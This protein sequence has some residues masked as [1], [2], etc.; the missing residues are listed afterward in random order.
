M[1]LC[2]NSVVCLLKPGNFIA[3]AILLNFLSNIKPHFKA[4]SQKLP[5]LQCL[6]S[7]VFVSDLCLLVLTVSGIRLVI[8]RSAKFVLGALTSSLFSL[9]SRP[10]L[11]FLLCPPYPLLFLHTTIL[12][13]IPT[14]SSK[15]CFLSLGEFII[16]RTSLKFPSPR[17]PPFI[18]MFSQTYVV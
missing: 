18:P 17:V 16:E 8:L 7:M 3:D 13:P 4:L 6:L 2:N 9:D 15:G 12:Y 14:S 10:S 11:S 1:L 5:G